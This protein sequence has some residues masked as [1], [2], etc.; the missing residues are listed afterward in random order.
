MLTKEI[1]VFVPRTS[2]WSASELMYLYTKNT[3]GV[4][5]ERDKY[6]RC[7]LT[8]SHLHSVTMPALRLHGI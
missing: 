7:F 1:T 6:M 5:F 2:N 8:I 4:H 3:S